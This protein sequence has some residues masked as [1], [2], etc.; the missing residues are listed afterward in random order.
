MHFGRQ[1]ILTD[2]RDITAQNVMQ[3][4]TD[5]MAIHEQNR[6]DCQFLTQYEKGD[7][8]ILGREKN[9]R[10]DI[11]NKVVENH[12]ASIVNFVTG[13]GFGQPIQYVQRADKDSSGEPVERDDA[14]IQLLNEMLHEQTKSS[15]DYRLA[16]LFGVNGVSYRLVL[17][18]R[19][20]RGPV[21]KQSLFDVLTLD[22]RTTFVV[23]S[24]DVY[25]DPVMAVSYQTKAGLGST[26]K[27]YGV[28]TADK[29]YTIDSEHPEA[30][31]VKDN[32][33]G[34]IPIIEY[35]YDEDRMGA[36]EKVIPLL[37]ALNTT[38]SNRVDGL[39][40]FIQSL[41][42]ILEAEVD[43]DTIAHAAEIGG[44]CI[45]SNSE[46]KHADIK[47]LQASLDQVGSQSLADDQLTKV[48][49]IS[50][51]PGRNADAQNTTG[52]AVLLSSGWQLAET[53]MKSRE[54]IFEE[55]EMRA[56][57]VMLAIIAAD[58]HAPAEL[59]SL[60]LSDIEIKFSR[61]RTDG[62]MTKVQALQILFDAGILNKHA[63]EACGL[64]SDVQTIWQDSKDTILEAHSHAEGT[65]DDTPVGGLGDKH[66][67]P[68]SV[69]DGQSDGGNH[70]QEA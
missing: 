64:W 46:N 35:R 48:W 30:M 4:L 53:A 14:G 24:N 25:R 33:I 31:R 7:Q 21:A 5:A 51:V 11:N 60:R 49:E 59:K 65:G 26:A 16:F 18:S 19:R 13:Y 15:K 61:N 27:V 10:S 52:E 57:E 29:I 58:P 56:L 50:G 43:D 44:I 28:Y 17:P 67:A 70:T 38:A 32:P 9:V 45:S 8:P 23:Y 41:L 6:A 63:L 42:V 69:T 1:V 37:D 47:L 22:P 54:H 66:D 68:N 12:A 2:E 34:I 39:E 3:V 55:S 62:L 36:F 20:T 40:Q